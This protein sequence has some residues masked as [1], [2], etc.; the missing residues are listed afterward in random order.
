MK[1]Q[2]LIKGTLILGI[3]GIIAKFLGVFFRWP[4]IMLI[5]DEGIGY[6]QMSY[7]LYTFFIAAASGVP[8]AVS[9]LVS[10]KN[11]TG[12]K[13]G[14][15]DVLKSAITFMT[16]IGGGFSAILLIFSKQLVIFFGWDPKSYYSLMGISLAP[17]IISIMSCFR[18]FFQGMQNMIPT[19]VSQIIEQI[20]R[21]L[22]GVGLAYILFPKGIEYSAGGAAFGA[23]AGGF[24]GGIYLIYKYLKVKKE[25]KF[26]IKEKD[27]NILTNLIKIAVPM[28]LGATVSSIMSVIDSLLVP[29]KLIEAGFSMEQATALFGQLTGKAFVLIGVPLTLSMSLCTSLVPIIAESHFLGR[30]KEV[31]NKVDTAIRI[32]TVIAFPCMLGLC[33]LARP[34]LQLIFP[35]HADGYNILQALSLSLPFII[36]TQATTYMLQGAG[37]EIKPIINLGI[38]CIIKIIITYILVPIPYINIYGSAISSLGAYLIAAVLNIKLLKKTFNYNIKYYDIMIKPAFASILMIITVVFIYMNV[39]NYTVSNAIS[40]IV[41]ILAGVILYSFLIIIF[42]TF[43]YSYIK[44]KLLKR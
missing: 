14:S 8:M 29:R 19:A 20:G 18:G 11:A 33:F 40:C 25:F 42:G 13:N 9:K 4:L 39:Y 2:S 5:G 21:V 3:A 7:P 35:G 37:E 34:I 24:L 17:I 32:S 6:Y 10:E 28:S 31:K 1:K 43:K 27:Y 38:A 30:S 44:E 36:I 15:L 22:I 26:R 12:D 23:A 16:I 41:S